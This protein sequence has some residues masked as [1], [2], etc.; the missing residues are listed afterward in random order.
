MPMFQYKA[1]SSA[2]ELQ[3][4]VMDGESHAKVIAHLQSTGLIPIRATE[5]GPTGKQGAGNVVVRA[6]ASKR[7]A[8]FAKARLSQ[9]DLGIL[10][11]ELATLL[12]AGLPLDRSMEILISLVEKPAVGDLLVAIRNDVRGGASLSK[13]L[14]PHRDVF[15]RFYIN[16]VKAG[17]VGGA[18]GNVLMRLADHMERSKEV[19]DSVISS[20][21]YPVILFVVAV[22]SVLVLVIFVVP[23][24]KQIFDQSGK[25]IPLATEIVLATGIFTRTFWP[26]MVGGVVV[27]IW[28]LVRSLNNP[29]SRAKWDVKFLRWPIMGK[30]VTK[31]EMAR[32]ARSLAILLQNGVPLLAGLSI[33]KDTMGNVVFRDAVEIVARDLKEG[34]GM[35]KPMN[36]ANVFPKLAVQMI[37]VGEETGKLDEMLFQ[38][39]DVYDREVAAAVKRALALIE[40]IMIVGLALIIGG[41]IMSLLVAMFGLMEIPL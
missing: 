9:D 21:V 18:L 12:K 4:G 29:V 35:A 37:A 20:L 2:G 17:E 3:E 1:V 39:A 26:A 11:R 23:Q 27:G 28:L 33:L 15:T 22:A 10:T 38:V 32:F 16:M 30:L 25:A 41:I 36:E 40:P 19:R 34:R 8:L 5:V 24:F 6:P 31:M 13:A 7:T 14:D